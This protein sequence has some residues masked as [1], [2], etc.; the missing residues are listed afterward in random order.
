MKKPKRKSKREF[1]KTI[2]YKGERRIMGELVVDCPKCVVPMEKKTNG[3]FVIDACPKCRGI[4]LDKR[5]IDNIAHQGFFNYV[6]A[7]FKRPKRVER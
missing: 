3:K 1:G 7:Y 6:M 5:E 4:F 2:V